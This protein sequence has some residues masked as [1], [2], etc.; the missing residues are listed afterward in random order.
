M[1]MTHLLKISTNTKLGKGI[2]AFSL[3]AVETCPGRTKLCEGICYATS[4]FFRF[5]KVQN[6]LQSNYAESLEDGF[7]DRIVNE[8]K[9]R[10]SIKAVRIH[11]SG[12]FYSA[13]YVGK[14][15]DIARACPDTKFWG[16]TRS[17]RTTV[18]KS[19]LLHAALRKLSE[20]PN[21]QLFASTDDETKQGPTPS[22]GKAIKKVAEN[23]PVWL[24]KAEVV[25]T[26][27]QLTD[28]TYVQCP[29]LKNK[30]I[31]CA[32]CT[33]CFKPPG[34]TKMNVAFTVH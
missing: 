12:D 29:N 34:K 2:A 23:P 20:L 30:N 24:R 13:E 18:P 25:E 17:W 31:T 7:T 14:W 1:G 10:R 33:Y 27:E 21:V 11:P 28:S 3:P 22:T 15:F 8:I 19:K 6:S 16:Y 5:P 4:G 26:W 32:A 9:S